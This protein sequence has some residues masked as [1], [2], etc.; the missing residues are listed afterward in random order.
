MTLLCTASQISPGHQPSG[1]SQGWRAKRM[2]SGQ[3]AQPDKKLR[4]SPIAH[5]NPIMQHSLLLSL[6]SFFPH[7]LQSLKSKPD[8]KTEGLWMSPFRCKFS[9]V[10]PKV[11]RKKKE[12]KREKDEI[13]QLCLETKP[14]VEAASLSVVGL[15]S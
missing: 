6:T 8:Q 2:P 15:C 4:G 1:Q 9:S 10:S 3:V 11:V 12:R 5:R 7:E 14:R 13:L